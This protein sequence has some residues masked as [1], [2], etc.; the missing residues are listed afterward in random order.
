[1]VW[2]SV[3]VLDFWWI[4]VWV[5]AEQIP[6]SWATWPRICICLD[7]IDPYS[8]PKWLTIL[9]SCCSCIRVPIAMHPYQCCIFFLFHFTH[10][11][12]Y[13]VVLVWISLMRNEFERLDVV[14]Q[15]CNPSFLGGK[16]QE[17]H[18]SRLAWAKSL[19]ASILTNGWVQWYI[20]VISAT[21]GSINMV[22]AQAFL[23]IKQDPTSKITNTNWS[24]TQKENL[25]CTTKR[26]L[27]L[28]KDILLKNQ[29]KEQ[30]T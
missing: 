25:S 3:L 15:S 1:M 4:Y 11:G 17:N 30:F 18:G 6:R 20:P 14:T 27:I 26:K 8:F 7:I 29:W 10:S 28:S 5:S 13:A 22:M 21:E 23:V 9:L 16:D 12:R 24:Q 19:Q 2:R